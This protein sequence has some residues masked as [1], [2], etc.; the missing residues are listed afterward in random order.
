MKKMI[1]FLTLAVLL[2]QACNKNSNDE[3]AEYIIEANNIEG[4]EN[5]ISIIARTVMENRI[6]TIIAVAFFENSGFT[7][8]LPSILPDKLLVPAADKTTQGVF[9]S[10]PLANW[11]FLNFSINTVDNSNLPFYSILHDDS[12]IQSDGIASKKVVY[13]YADRH[14]TL[15]GETSWIYNTLPID[16]FGVPTSQQFEF[17]D[18]YDHLALS[19]GWNKICLEET[20]NQTV[21]PFTLYRTYSMKNTNDCRWNLQIFQFEE[22]YTYYTRWNIER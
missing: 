17:I 18:T 2:M 8:R 3:V 22:E 11:A 12:H 20:V 15:S 14:V 7:L 16:W 5:L 1:S 9:I 21:K 10:D 6:G 4:A 19:A 13:V